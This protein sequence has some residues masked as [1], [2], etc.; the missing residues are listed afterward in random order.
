MRD[1]DLRDTRGS[2]LAVTRIADLPGCCPECRRP[3][4]IDRTATTPLIRAGGVI[5]VRVTV[6]ACSTCEYVRAIPDATR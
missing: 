1:G 5:E 4:Y 6:V 3:M 2:E